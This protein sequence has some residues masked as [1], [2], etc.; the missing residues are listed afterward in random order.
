MDLLVHSLNPSQLPVF[1]VKMAWLLLT[2]ITNESRMSVVYH[3]K[4]C[5]TQVVFLFGR[6]L[7]L[8]QSCG[9]DLLFQ[10]QSPL[11]SSGDGKEMEKHVWEV[12]MDQA[13]MGNTWFL[14]II[15]AQNSITWY[16]QLQ[17]RVGKYS[18]CGLKRKRKP[19]WSSRIKKV[20]SFVIYF[21]PWVT[22][23][24]PSSPVSFHFV[25]ILICPSPFFSVPISWY[26][27]T[28][29]SPLLQPILHSLLPGSSRSA[30]AFSSFVFSVPTGTS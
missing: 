28:L 27:S 2:T 30:A 21:S 3:N 1:V 29:C 10:V 18:S 9:F 7:G 17:G 4:P 26:T 13:W 6:D 14:F 20:S 25:I 22:F 16:T 5:E 8:L 11:H 24:Q 15:F 12:F 23:S 19:H